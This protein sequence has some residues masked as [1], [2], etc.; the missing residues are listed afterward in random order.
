MEKIEKLLKSFSNGEI[1]V[2]FDDEDR[3]NEADLIVAID[4][5]TPEKVNFLA[6]YGKGLICA[7][8]ST[9]IIMQKGFPLMPS[10]KTDAHATAFTISVD[11][12]SVKTGISPYE[13][14][15]TSK[16]L[17]DP[18]KTLKDFI[19]PGHL[20]PLAAKRGG[21]LERRGHTEA[22]TSLCK[23]ANLPEA[24]L[25]CEMVKDDGNMLSIEEAQNFSKKYN[26]PF[27]TVE[28]L[29]EYQKLKYSNVQKIVTA[30]LPTDFG[31][32]DITIYKELYQNKEHVFLSMGDYTN[33]IVRVHS[34]CLTGDVFSSRTCDCRAQLIAGLQ[35]ISDDKKGAIVYLRQEGRG[36]GLAEKIKAYHLQQTKGLDTVDANLHL[37][38]KADNRDFHQAAWILKDQGFKSVRILTNNPEKTDYLKQHNLEIIPEKFELHIS[39]ENYN[40]LKTKKIKL[41]HNIDI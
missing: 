7:S 36:I 5:L 8:L 4:K 29:V 15:I 14:Y 27:C 6:T 10:N 22:A 12:K 40:Y 35:K 24:A 31:V 3:E 9:D 39:K 16:D 11:S 1:V 23:W 37:G 17:L 18:E 34:E 25:I 38:H 21:L 20:F 2:V 32:F 26:L 30:K 33:G 19:T 41:G 13:R 28:E